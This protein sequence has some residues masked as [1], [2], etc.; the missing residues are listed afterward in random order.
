MNIELKDDYKFLHVDAIKYCIPRGTV[1]FI[2]EVINGKNQLPQTYCGKWNDLSVNIPAFKCFEI[3][4]KETNPEKLKQIDDWFDNVT[5][6]IT[7]E[8]KPIVKEIEL[9]LVHDGELKKSIKF[10][11]NGFDTITLDDMIDQKEKLNSFFEEK[12][13][14]AKND[15]NY[16]YYGGNYT[17]NIN[18]NSNTLTLSFGEESYSEIRNRYWKWALKYFGLEEEKPKYTKMKSVERYGVCRIP[19]YDEMFFIETNATKETVDEFYD[20]D[21]KKL[22][23][24]LLKE[25]FKAKAIKIDYILSTYEPIKIIKT[26]KLVL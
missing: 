5:E 18:F 24:K 21:V 10:K 4:E 13:D 15:G 19:D 3:Y 17:P 9:K 12:E 22:V 16:D 26:N 8:L 2:D 11:L 23:D 14:N 1:I 25:K 6:K 7:S 20:G